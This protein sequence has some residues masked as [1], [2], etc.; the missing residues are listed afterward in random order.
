MVAKH[1]GQFY[2]DTGLAQEAAISVVVY[3]TGKKKPVPDYSAFSSTA[4]GITD[5]HLQLSLCWV[6]AIK[7]SDVADH[8]PLNERPLRPGLR[9]Q[10]TSERL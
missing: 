10:R 4:E 5:V 2:S 3:I 1:G 7:T 9:D 8:D 6:Y